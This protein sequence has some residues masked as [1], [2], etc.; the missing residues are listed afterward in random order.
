LYWFVEP[1]NF[2][3]A[4]FQQMLDAWVK[5]G[6]KPSHVTLHGPFKTETEINESQRM[7][8]FGAQCEVTEGGMWDPNW[9]KM[10]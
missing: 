2:S 9:E 7:V 1:P 6:R 8:L 3:E 4:Q 10:Q 5:A